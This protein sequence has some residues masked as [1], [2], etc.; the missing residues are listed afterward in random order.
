V[1]KNFGERNTVRGMLER[2]TAKLEWGKEGRCGGGA[3]DA[4]YSAGAARRQPVGEE[5]WRRPMDFDCASFTWGRNDE[6]GAGYWKRS[7][8]G[9]GEAWCAEGEEKAAHG[10]AAR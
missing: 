3:R 10:V 1:K 5:R 6:W 9:D 2:G 7:G 8:G 4:F